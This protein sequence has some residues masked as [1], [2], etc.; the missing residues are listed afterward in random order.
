MT[1]PTVHYVAAPKGGCGKSAIAAILTQYWLELGY[2]V[3]ALDFDHAART[4]AGYREL[5]VQELYENGELEEL[6]DHIE[7][8]G[9]QHLIVDTNSGQFG[10]LIRAIRNNQKLPV[11]AQ[12]MHV[13]ICGGHGMEAT[14]RGLEWTVR[15][16]PLSHVLWKSSYWEGAGD[17]P[18]A[19]IE[20]NQSYGEHRHRIH[21]VVEIPE[22]SDSLFGSAWKMVL[23]R[24]LTWEETLAD[25]SLDLM[26]RHRIRR[27]RDELTGRIDMAQLDRIAE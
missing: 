26:V 15:R 21:A 1:Q 6:D 11:K 12:I 16:L 2:E 20:E 14:V 25:K 13:V 27:I 23:E 24:R 4:L 22:Y 17:M 5:P 10:S 18:G 3:E 19:D 8:S 9:C 7:S